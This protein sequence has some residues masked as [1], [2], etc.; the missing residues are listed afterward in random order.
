MKSSKATSNSKHRT[1]KKENTE[2]Q[3]NYCSFPKRIGKNAD[4]YKTVI[5]THNKPL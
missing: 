3:K 1:N 2:R 4:L 5:I